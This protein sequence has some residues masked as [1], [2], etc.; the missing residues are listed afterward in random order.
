MPRLRLAWTRH[1]TRDFAV[2]IEATNSPTADPT[3]DPDA[4]PGVT[5]NDLRDM[6]DYDADSGDLTWRVDRPGVERGRSAGTF[7]GK[8]LVLSVNGVKVSAS[9]AIMAMMTGQWPRERVRFANGN[10][11]DLS[12]DN[13]TGRKTS[14]T[15]TRETIAR[16]ELRRVNKAAFEH[17]RSDPARRRAFENSDDREQQKMIAEA[18]DYLRAMKPQHFPTEHILP[19]GRPRTLTLPERMAREAAKQQRR[20]AR[21]KLKHAGA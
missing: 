7:V 20:R 1:T 21:R 12:F 18:R 16:R 13:L 14:P 17:I 10:P 8:Y 11:A 9:R 6:F 15:E 4:P 19:R 5:I 3:I 2:G